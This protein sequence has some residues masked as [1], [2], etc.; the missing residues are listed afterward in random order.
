MGWSQYR[1]R[2]IFGQRGWHA[3]HHNG[4]AYIPSYSEFI[5]LTH[6]LWQ[7]R[8]K[9]LMDE[10]DALKASYA[11]RN[12]HVITRFCWTHISAI[13]FLSN[14]AVELKQS[15]GEDAV[16]NLEGVVEEDDSVSLYAIVVWRGDVQSAEAAIDDFDER[17]W[18][19][20]RAQTRTYV[21]VRTC[22]MATPGFDWSHYLTVATRLSANADEASQRSSISRACYCIYHKAS[23]R[24]VAN[25]YIDQKSHFELWALYDKNS[26]DRLCRKLHSIGTRM[27][28]E[29]VE[30]DYNPTATRI[31]ERMTVQLNRATYFLERLATLAAG[32]PV[33]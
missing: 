9:K 21:Y 30:A 13:P 5:A 19:S 3:N 28:K 8:R 20:Q 6:A 22:V 24:A 31:T 23:E 25:G 27:K 10:V 2:T 1:T 7:D 32:L 16:L 29:R 12:E 14:A 33:P 4:K 11:F 26:T 18:F 17:W 15:F